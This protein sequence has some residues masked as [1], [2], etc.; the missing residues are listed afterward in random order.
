MN[1]VE[2]SIGDQFDNKPNNP[3]TWS[4]GQAECMLLESEVA[5]SN[6]FSSELNQSKLNN[7]SYQNNHP[8]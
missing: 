8:E 3:G 5:N 2:N 1:A 7:E 4:D 6:I